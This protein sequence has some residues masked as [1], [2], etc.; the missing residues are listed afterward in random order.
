KFAD[1]LAA[2][3]NI[4]DQQLVPAVQ[5]GDA[6]AAA[7]VVAGPMASANETFADPLD[8]LFERLQAEVRPALAASS[9]AYS[10]SRTGM[11]IALVLGTLAAVALAVGIGRMI[12]G[13]LR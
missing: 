12:L 8:K 4:R 6:A 5:N 10:S 3:R 1:G 2:W 13:P 11:V 7:A 9:S